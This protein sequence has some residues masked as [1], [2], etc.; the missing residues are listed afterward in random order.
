MAMAAQSK[1]HHA[2]NASRSE[3]SVESKAPVSPRE[4]YK[5]DIF[6]SLKQLRSGQVIDAEQSVREIRGELGIDAN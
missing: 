4:E 3:E 2:H 6:V 1:K 5:N